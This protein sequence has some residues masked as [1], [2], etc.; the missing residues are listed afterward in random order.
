[1]CCLSKSSNSSL[2]ECIRSKA[3]PRNATKRPLAGGRSRAVDVREG[4]DVDGGASGHFHRMTYVQV[5]E[6]H[7]ERARRHIGAALVV[8]TPSL[9]LT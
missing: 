1:M 4:T 8:T 5:I 3:E 9:V 6:L 2:G 7:V